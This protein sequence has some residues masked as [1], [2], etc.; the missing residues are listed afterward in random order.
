[1]L[2]TQLSNNQKHCES[3]EHWVWSLMLEHVVQTPSEQLVAPP[4]T[5]QRV[6]PGAV[7]QSPVAMPVRLAEATP[8]SLSVS[9][10]VASSGVSVLGVKVTDNEHEAPVVSVTA[11]HPSVLTE[12]SVGL[13]PASR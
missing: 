2:G 13:S 11:A 5:P 10:N 1:M 6:P 3:A 8:P 7:E 9:D 4:S 12:K